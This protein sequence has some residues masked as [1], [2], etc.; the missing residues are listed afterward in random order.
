MPTKTKKFTTYNKKDYNSG[1][2][3]LTSVWGPSLWHFLHTMSFNYPVKPNKNDKKHYRDYILSLKHILPC[4][5][6]RKN[7]TKNFK[8]LPIN[9]KVMKNRE[10]FS[11]YIF[12]L[13]ELINT[14]L[15]KSSGL[16]YEEVRDKYENFRSRCTIDTD[17]KSDDSFSSSTAM[18]FMSS[19]I[20]KNGKTTQIEMGCTKPL[21]GKKSK[22]IIRIV[23]HDTPGKTFDID[24]KCI[25]R[26]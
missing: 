1:D 10:S 18:S 15:G 3:M 12:N 4:G 2:G 6:C 17:N 19:K 23:P 7:L 24:N 14:M 25:K 5:Y 8:K 13:H 21:Y 22:C 20:N 26:K 16:L 9:D 11:K